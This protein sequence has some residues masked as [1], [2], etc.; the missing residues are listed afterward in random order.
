MYNLHSHL[1]HIYSSY[2][3][4]YILSQPVYTGGKFKRGDTKRDS[5]RWVCGVSLSVASW[6]PPSVAGERALLLAVDL[7]KN[8]F[9]H[10]HTKIT[11]AV[12]STATIAAAISTMSRLFLFSLS[13]VCNCIIS[14]LVESI[15]DSPLV[16][17]A[18][19][20]CKKSFTA[21]GCSCNTWCSGVKNNVLIV[22]RITGFR[23]TV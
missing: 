5:G 1:Q 8:P 19:H 14:C 17:K 13:C 10:T 11:V 15:V 9:F 12:S 18:S 22:G 20:S 6:S 4:I 7:W 21:S 23:S 16:F 2:Y 3:N